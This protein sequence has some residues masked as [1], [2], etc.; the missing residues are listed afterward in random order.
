MGFTEIMQK[1]GQQITEPCGNT[2]AKTYHDH[3]NMEG[4]T[5]FVCGFTK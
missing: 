1:Q 3:E 2:F 5:E 4:E